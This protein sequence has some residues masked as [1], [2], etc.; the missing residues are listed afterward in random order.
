MRQARSRADNAPPRT[1]GFRQGWI[2]GCPAPGLRSGMSVTVGLTRSGVATIFHTR[3]KTFTSVVILDE[4]LSIL[5]GGAPG[6]PIDPRYVTFPGEN[7]EGGFR[8]DY[9]AVPDMVILRVGPGP[10]GGWQACHG[11]DEGGERRG[12]EGV[13]LP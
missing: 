13:A 6:R 10:A 7:N 4:G 2:G 9:R 12:A 8:H 3:E 1:H 5:L 11:G